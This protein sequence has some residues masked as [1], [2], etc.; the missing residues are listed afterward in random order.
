ME[1]LNLISY[2]NSKESL[3]I[4]GSE[5]IKAERLEEA[6]KLVSEYGA[7]YGNVFVSGS[8]LFSQNYNDIDIFIIRT[9]GY[10]EEWK[11][12]LHLIHISESRISKP[13][14]QSAALISV[15]NF[16]ILRKISKKRPKLD[17]LMSD[18]H[19]AVIEKMK[20]EKK[21]EAARRII[22]DY[23]LLVGDKLLNAKELKE[24]TN[25]ISLEKI[26]GMMRE[27]CTNIFSKK[28]L[29]IGLHEYIKTLDESIKNITPNNHLLRYK[30][31]YEAMIYERRR[32]KAKA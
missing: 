13:I 2:E 29:Y 28:Y 19:E 3:Y 27:I 15:S 31:N 11:N 20:N 4:S 32:G 14:F 26:D 30:T 21:N 9:R 18:Y 8:F 22:F 25:L 23:Y 12:N 5:N 1:A 24:L 7:K 10:K 17:D 6:K 16:P